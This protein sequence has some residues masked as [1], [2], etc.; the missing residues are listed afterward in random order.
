MLSIPIKIEPDNHSFM[1]R[2]V[3]DEVGERG[4]YGSL[5]WVK[6]GAIADYEIN[7]AFAGVTSIA[8]LTEI[9]FRN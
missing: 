2:W 7:V 8:H 4:G 6:N 3:R 9:I 1:H 5:V